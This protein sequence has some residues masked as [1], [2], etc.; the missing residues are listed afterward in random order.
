MNTLIVIFSC[1]SVFIC[2]FVMGAH[3]KQEDVWMKKTR[4]LI[5]LAQAFNEYIKEKN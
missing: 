3:F 5:G 2:G 4:Q 1:A